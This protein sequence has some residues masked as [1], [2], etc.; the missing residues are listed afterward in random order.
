M[1]IRKFKNE[2]RKVLAQLGL[3]P[4][5]AVVSAGGGLMMYGLREETS[6]IDMDIPA[7]LYQALKASGKFEVKELKVPHYMRATLP[8]EPCGELIVLNK[9]VDVHSMP[10]GVPVQVRK[11][12][13]VYTPDALLLQ[14]KALNRDKDQRDIFLLENL[15]ARLEMG[16]MTRYI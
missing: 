13:G 7:D 1:D 14:K 5:Q 2:Y 6:D 12:V 4:Q 8:W 11:G 9:Y 15:I 16:R 10:E 3:K